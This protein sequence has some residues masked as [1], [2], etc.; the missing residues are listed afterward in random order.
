MPLI[1][2]YW[3]REW[4]M[5][6]EKQIQLF[7]KYCTKNFEA[8]IKGVRKIEWEYFHTREKARK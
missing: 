4:Q 5:I 6:T 8:E 3:G 1:R 2:A 7:S